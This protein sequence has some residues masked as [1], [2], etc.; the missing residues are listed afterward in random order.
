V[1]G[2]ELANCCIH[3]EILCL[4]GASRNHGKTLRNSR[5][6]P[7]RASVLS[8][9]DPSTRVS[10]AAEDAREPCRAQINI[11]VVVSAVMLR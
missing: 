8:N 11:H 6:L 4:S 7:V 3:A 5:Y 2:D 1:G 10:R 9:Q